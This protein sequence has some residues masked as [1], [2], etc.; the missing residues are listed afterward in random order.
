MLGQLLPQKEN[1]DGNPT[2]GILDYK[3]TDN[4]QPYSPLGADANIF[5]KIS[6]KYTELNKVGA[7]K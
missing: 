2:G 1:Q 7:L 4:M 3:N 5:K 6:E